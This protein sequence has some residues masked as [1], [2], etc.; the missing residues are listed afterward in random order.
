MLATITILLAGRAAEEI[1][2]GNTTTGAS[3]DM[4]RTTDL[5]RKMVCEWGMSKLGPLTFGKN[6][7]QI[8]L[9][10]EISRH[11]YYSESTAIKIDEELKRIISDC[12]QKTRNILKENRKALI[13]LAQALLEYETLESNEVEA[14]IKGETIRQAEKQGEPPNSSPDSNQKEIK[15][16]AK[17][18]GPM[19]NP[20]ERPATA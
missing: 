17:Q 20:S 2:L 11:Q 8:F 3:N 14:I 7:E 13:R 16:D 10:R 1:F 19:V 9:G 6:E 5:A 15:E 18:V 4:E 12:D